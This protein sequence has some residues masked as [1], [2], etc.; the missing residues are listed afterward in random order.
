[1]KNAGT[2]SA[3]ALMSDALA[4]F[5]FERGDATTRMVRRDPACGGPRAI[6]EPGC[7]ERAL[8]VASLDLG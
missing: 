5:G 3:G 7:P 2:F 4:R 8:T 6:T 1:V